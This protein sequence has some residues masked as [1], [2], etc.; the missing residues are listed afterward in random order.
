MSVCK[1][2][3]YRVVG[4]KPIFNI[5]N[6]SSIKCVMLLLGSKFIRGDFLFFCFTFVDVKALLIKSSTF[7]LKQKANFL[8][9]EMSESFS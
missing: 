4:T 8:N 7:Y 3:F 1:Y 5:T 6:T 9:E 2:I